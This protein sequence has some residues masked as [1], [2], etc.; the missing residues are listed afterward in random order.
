MNIKIFKTL[1]IYK[2][3][4]K[5]DENDREINI[6]H[7]KDC[8]AKGINLNYPNVLLYN[9]DNLILPL[10]EKT[11]SLRES[12]YQK[13][14]M[15]FNIKNKR[16]ENNYKE[17]LFF[18]CYNVN[19]YY[20]FLYDTLPYLISYLELK[21]EIKN[22]KLLTNNF[23]YRFV[24]EF[25]KLLCIE[26]EDLIIIKDNIIY[27][28]IYISTSY[29]H[30]IDSNLPPRK[31]IFDFYEMLIEKA[32]E[33]NN[34]DI[35]LYDKIY[36]SRRTHIHNKLDNIGTNYT[37]RRKLVNEDQLVKKLIKKGYQEI[38][39]E[40]LTTIEKILLFNSAKNICGCIGGGIANVVFCKKEANLEAIISPGF[41][42]INKRFKY[43]LD[44]VKVNYN[45]NTEHFE[46]GE[47]KKYMRIKYKDMIG[48]IE[49]YDEENIYVKITDGS[50]VGWDLDKKFNLVKLN[51]K[52]NIIK[53]DNGL[54]SAFFI[55]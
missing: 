6:Y 30:D 43:C 53:L 40:N 24:L 31:E 8:L 50:N 14:D 22:L 33:K 27:E 46:K 54:N 26:K 1:K 47:F 13:N 35:K 4:F 3:I 55:F 52:E 29:T 32:K 2:K 38:F 39:T 21:K 41:L 42:D 37:T 45:F 11:M 49:D 28:N 12:Y 7:M 16:I 48:E 18:F 9:A 36:I 34:K 10:L 23:K 51:K 17:P 15:K 19:N 20:H 25:L 44:W 5:K